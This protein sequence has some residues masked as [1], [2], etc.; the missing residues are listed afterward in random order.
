[1]HAVTCCAEIEKLKPSNQIAKKC[2]R[3]QYWQYHASI[4]KVDPSKKD[5]GYKT[6]LL[7][8]ILF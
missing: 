3:E 5:T 1:M 2:L 7:N 8:G 4:I 6:V